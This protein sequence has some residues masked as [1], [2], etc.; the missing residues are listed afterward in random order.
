VRTLEASANDDVHDLFD[1]V[2]TGMFADAKAVGQRE[3]L[4]SIHDL[5]A[6]DLKLKQA[7]AVLLDDT[8]SNA[9]VRRTCSVSYRGR[10]SARP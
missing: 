3:R 7:C 4:R 2:V 6:A 8:T 9:R 10:N 1:D 5:D